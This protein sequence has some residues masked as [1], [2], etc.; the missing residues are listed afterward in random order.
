VPKEATHLTDNEIQ[1]NVN[2]L[3]PGGAGVVIE[4]RPDGEIYIINLG[5]YIGAVDVILDAWYNLFL[6]MNDNFDIW[7]TYPGRIKLHFFDSEG[8]IQTI[9]EPNPEADMEVAIGRLLS[10]AGKKFEE[11][12]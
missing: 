2:S 9:D 1:I 12:K 10:K 8:N 3:W 7:K 11:C 5:E 6:F 4:R